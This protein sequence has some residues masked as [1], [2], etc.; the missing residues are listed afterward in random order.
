[1]KARKVVMDKFGYI[2]QQMIR[3]FK[4][5]EVQYAYAYNSSFDE[6][7]FDYNCEWFKC[8]NPFDNI[9]VLD[10]RGNV[11]EFIA[12]SAHFQDFCEEYQCFTDSGNYS[13]TAET[14]FQYISKEYDFAEAHTALA[15]SEI[16]LKIL[17]STVQ[18]GAEW[19]KVYKTAISIVRKSIKHLTIDYKGE[20]VEYEYTS[21]RNLKDKIILK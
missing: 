14:L 13:T 6:K 16:E 17:L 12:R 1:M 15:D 3:D 5:Y 2:C 4:A 8:N 19:G 11:H 10:I 9:P 20:V 7:V 21:R 18:R